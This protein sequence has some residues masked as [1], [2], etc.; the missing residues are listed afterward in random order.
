MTDN[1]EVCTE[2]DV[3]DIKDTNV[4]SFTYNNC[5]YQQV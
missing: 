1:N 4:S 2:L 5:Q 3:K